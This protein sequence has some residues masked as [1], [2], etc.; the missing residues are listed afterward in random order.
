MSLLQYH[1]FHSLC[2]DDLSY[3]IFRSVPVGFREN[4]FP[5]AVG[6]S[7]CCRVVYSCGSNLGFL[8]YLGWPEGPRA[9]EYS[10]YFFDYCLV[11][12]YGSSLNVRCY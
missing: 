1:H 10:G 2:V 6:V 9:P 4:P 11:T 8:A 5:D 3:R 12:R 7:L